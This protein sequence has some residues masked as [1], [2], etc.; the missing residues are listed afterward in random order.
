VIRDDGT[1]GAGGHTCADIGL[2]LAQDEETRKHWWSVLHSQASTGYEEERTAITGADKPNIYVVNGGY[3]G[4]EHLSQTITYSKGISID[5][6]NGTIT[7]ANPQ[8]LTIEIGKE[9]EIV[10]SIEA[11]TA[12]FPVYVTGFYSDP[13]N[14]YYLP[15]T[16]TVFHQTSYL[17]D[18]FSATIT[19]AWIDEHGDYTKEFYLNSDTRVPADRAACLVTSRVF[20]IAQGETTYLQSAERNAYPDYAVTDGRVYRY[21]GVPFTNARSAAS[22]NAQEYTGT[23]T[24][25]KPVSLTFERMPQLVVIAPLCDTDTIYTSINPCILFPLYGY[26]FVVGAGKPFTIEVDGKTIR[27]P[28]RM[29]DEGQK[30]LAMAIG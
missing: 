10:A 8:S 4:A 22:V 2:A 15:D 1:I 29:N 7:L 16:A 21:L 17:E 27:V 20:N 23:G 19:A 18:N 12:L 9:A 3:T 30:Y 11:I 24:A 28:D 13:D 14:I 26:S 6:T 5:Q 25:E